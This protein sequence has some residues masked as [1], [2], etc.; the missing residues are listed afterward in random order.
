MAML[1]LELL[2]GFFAE[3]GIADCVNAENVFLRSD[4]TPQIYP[5]RIKFGKLQIVTVSRA[6]KK[7][8]FRIILHKNSFIR[9]SDFA[10]IKVEK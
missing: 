8:L 4:K 6:D 2:I 9:K 3:C 5:L 7:L 10:E 1:N